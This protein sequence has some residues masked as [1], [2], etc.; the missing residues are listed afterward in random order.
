MSGLSWGAAGLL[1][2]GLVAVPLVSGPSAG[3]TRGAVVAAEVPTLNWHPCRKGLECASA[4]VPLDYD[5][6]S[7]GNTRIFM[8]RRPA[9]D[10]ARRIGSLFLNPGGPGA[11]A[12]R[13]VKYFA[14]VLPRAVRARFDLIGIDPR[15]TGLSS[16]MR[17]AT[18]PRLPA[19]PREST[20]RTTAQSWPVLRVYRALAQAC[21]DHSDPIVAHMSTADTARDMDLVRQALGEPTLSYYGVSGGSILGATYAALFPDHVRAVALDSVVDPIA[22]TT[23]RG[24][25]SE[26]LP[27]TTRIGSGV[28][29]WDALTSA[30]S[31]CDRVGSHRCAFAGSAAAKWARIVRRLEKGPADALG[32]RLYY[33]DLIEGV[34]ETLYARQAYPFLMRIL[35]QIHTDMFGGVNRSALPRTPLRSL[36]SLADRHPLPLATSSSRASRFEDQSFWTALSGITC[37]DGQNP[38]RSRDWIH[39]GVVADRRGPWFGRLWT[40]WSAA[41][42][43]W[44]GAGNDAFRGPW[45][46]TTAVPLLLLNTLHDNATPISGARVVNTL[47]EGSRLVTLDSWGH[48]VVGRGACVSRS[49]RRYLV[50]QTLPPS[51]QVCQPAKHLFPAAR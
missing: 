24:H 11:P 40:W 51:G 37:A 19:L 10:S 28:G 43:A 44:H 26:T 49:I 48:T 23:G 12:S 15:G 7:A 8:T 14:S 4:F 29:A 36:R 47:F 39:A 41:C 17:C 22:W 46:T 25:Q 13:Y 45:R 38:D 30:F 50:D 18:T 31:E 34:H 42:G 1:V 3:T 32:E 9:D 27:S 16:P 35:R 2:V 20:P 6:P 5:E 21:T 33:S